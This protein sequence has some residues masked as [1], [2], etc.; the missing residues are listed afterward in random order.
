M[1]TDGRADGNRHDNRGEGARGLEGPRAD[2]GRDR[3]DRG[4]ERPREPRPPREGF[5]PRSRRLRGG[6]RQA[7]ERQEGERVPVAEQRPPVEAAVE[8]PPVRA[9]TPVVPEAELPLEAP[10]AERRPR[11]R[12]RKVVTPVETSEAPAS[13][14][15]DM[16]RLPPAF[17][18]AGDAPAAE[19]KPRRTRRPRGETAAV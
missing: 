14:R 5:E 7:E 15:I 6:E 12:P 18:D 16:D 13:E 8:A 19:A 4:D 1:R 2:A 3:Q 9:E 11:G 17:A 10:V